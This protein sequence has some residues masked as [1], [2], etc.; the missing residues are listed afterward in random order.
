MPDHF[1]TRPPDWEDVRFFLAL[2]RGGSLSAAARSLHVNHA[3]VSRRV[4]ALERSV[5]APLFVRR[6]D[7]YLPTRQGEALLEA[8][9]AMEKAA[10]Q[11]AEA[12]SG[13]AGGGTVRVTTV[14]SLA[15]V[16]LVD[17]LCPL[18]SAHPGLTIEIITEVRLMSLARREADIALRLGRPRDSGL[19]GRKV[20]EVHY[21]FYVSREV[22]DYEVGGLPLVAYDLDADGIVEAAWVAKRYPQRPVSFRS[23]SNEA[24]AAAARAGFGLVMLPRYMGDPDPRLRRVDSMEVHPARDLW[25]LSPPGLARTPRVRTVLDALADAVSSGQHLLSGQAGQR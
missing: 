6:A 8:A 15:D 11:L 5:G 14:R 19:V 16:F 25:L 18:R 4:S 2:F 21:G 1:R 17:R 13:H 10:A 9:L 7:G 23:N 22:P 12:V 3:T 20:A 24:Q